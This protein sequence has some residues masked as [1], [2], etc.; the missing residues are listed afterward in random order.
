M[1]AIAQLYGIAETAKALSVGRT[2]IY[3]MFD[4]GDL[5]PIK[6]GRRTLVAASEISAYIESRLSALK[7]GA[8]V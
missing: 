8:A 7:A 3:G 4:S 6:I 5:T 1:E 2:T